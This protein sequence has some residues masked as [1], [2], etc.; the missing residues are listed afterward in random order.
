MAQS[1]HGDP[2]TQVQI[3]LAFSIPEIGTL[4]I[5]HHQIKA[6]V[7]RHHILVECLFDIIGFITHQI[8]T[9]S[10]SGEL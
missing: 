3:A 1:V 6:P 7:T 9:S 10:K 5:L 8:F 2:G 4:P